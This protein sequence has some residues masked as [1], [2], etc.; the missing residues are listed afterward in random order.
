DIHPDPDL[1]L[2]TGPEQS[3]IKV[4]CECLR[5]ASKVFDAMMK[6][7]WVESRALSLKEISLPE[8][9]AEAMGIICCALHYRNS[10]VPDSLSPESILH[11]ALIVDKYDL[12]EALNYHSTQW[13][14]SSAKAAREDMAQIGYLMA[15]ALR[16]EELSQELIFHFAGSYKTLMDDEVL[17]NFIPWSC[18]RM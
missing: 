11:T 6:S 5:L 2:I 13:L 9:D 16:F 3:Q 12:T 1:I 17:R 4:R 15:A 10:L 7:P 14:Q 18:I 8:D